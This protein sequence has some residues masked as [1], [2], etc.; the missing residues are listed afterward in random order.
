MRAK[1]KQ[2]RDGPGQKLLIDAESGEPGP[3]FR[4]L[5]DRIRTALANGERVI[6]C[7]DA[8][9]FISRRKTKC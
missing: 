7:P 6:L 2:L 1:P 4:G 3:D 9:G 5:R 8:L